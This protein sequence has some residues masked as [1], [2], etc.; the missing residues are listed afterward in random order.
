MFS[1]FFFKCLKRNS[2]K[3][4][5]FVFVVFPNVKMRHVKKKKKC[6]LVNHDLHLTVLS[7]IFLNT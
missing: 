6:Y 7:F 4:L 3:C 5:G 1:S 2:L